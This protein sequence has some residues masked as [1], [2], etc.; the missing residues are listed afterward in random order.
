MVNQR[1]EV[2][3]AAGVTPSLV[4][5]YFPDHMEMIE[6]AT[7]PVVERYMR[8]LMAI[9]ESTASNDDK[10]R[11]VVLLL[12]ETHSL[13]PNVVDCYIDVVRRKT[14][15]HEQVEHLLQGYQ[16]LMTFFGTAEFSEFAV[17]AEPGFLVFALWGMCRGVAQDAALPVT[18]EGSSANKEQLVDRVLKLFGNRPS[19]DPAG[20]VADHHG[21]M[22]TGQPRHRG[23]PV[24]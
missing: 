9:L 6:A 12:I 2:A 7:K 21:A 19:P 13:E 5:Y 23:F 22:E 11:S 24:L 17:S 16:A 10:L 14:N 18:F 8:A 1:T 3:R 20:Q 15:G 4:C